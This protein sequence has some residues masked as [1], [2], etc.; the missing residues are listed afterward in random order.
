MCFHFDSIVTK[1]V[2]DGLIGSGDYTDLLQWNNM[3]N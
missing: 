1:I 3:N 2:H